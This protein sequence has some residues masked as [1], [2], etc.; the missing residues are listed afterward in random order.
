MSSTSKE[1]TRLSKLNINNES[2]KNSNSNF[3]SLSNIK[4]NEKV[5]TVYNETQTS[6][7]DEIKKL[8]KLFMIYS[9]NDKK[10][11]SQKYLKLLFDA[12]IL[13]KAFDMRRADI[14]LARV[15]KLKV[16]YF[17]NFCDILVKIAEIKFPTEF[18]T[19][20][21]KILNKLLSLYIFPLF[22][23]LSNSSPNPKDNIENINRNN[24]KSMIK[25]NYTLFKMIYVKYFP[26]ENLTISYSHKKKLSEKGFNKFLSDFEIYPNLI[27]KKIEM[28]IL[29]EMYLKNDKILNLF[30]EFS[31]YNLGTCFTIFSF[32]TS[33]YLV[34]LSSYKSSDYDDNCNIPLN[35]DS[36]LLMLEKLFKSQAMSNLVTTKNTKEYDE[37]IYRL[38]TTASYFRQTESNLDE[39]FTTLG[40][41]TVI[42]TCQNSNC[43]TQFNNNEN[44]NFDNNKD[45]VSQEN[46]YIKTQMKDNQFLNVDELEINSNF[47][48]QYKLIL[49]RVFK[50]Y[51]NSSDCTNFIYMNFSSFARLMSDCGILEKI[52][53]ERTMNFDL[54]FNLRVSSYDKNRMNS[55]KAKSSKKCFGFSKINA[56]FSKFSSEYDIKLDESVTKN[57]NNKLNYTYFNTNF[58]QFK[59]NKVEKEKTKVFSNKKINFHEFLKIL[60]C[61]S[62]KLYDECLPFPS[63]SSNRSLKISLNKSN[64]LFYVDPKK[65]TIYLEKFINEYI[66]S[67]YKEIVLIFENEEQDFLLLNE[68]I[69]DNYIVYHKNNSAIYYFKI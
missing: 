54:G 51:C 4:I 40:D 16:L 22:D 18:Q 55:S 2:H 44:N 11:Q 39:F 10:L 46:Y 68:L 52:D 37:I 62:N 12:G 15:S 45:E 59:I 1:V 34:A 5:E 36:F 56:I 29:E 60:M 38:N 69:S 42:K 67:I 31:A 23:K 30:T 20:K 41:E 63:I 7:C 58:N 6:N 66:I 9:N 14:L 25:D 13:D 61:I 53:R 3:F 19:N 28:E 35:K 32:I 8:K 27:S 33:I 48:A 43:I 21:N 49:I 47:F 65:V 24:I 57:L 50:F 17:D 64:D 26:W